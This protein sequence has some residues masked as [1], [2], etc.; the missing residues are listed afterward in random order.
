M[1]IL[2][3]DRTYEASVKLIASILGCLKSQRSAL[4]GQGS[5]SVTQ[6]TFSKETR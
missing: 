5:G 4:S 2:E 6:V 3:H 1:M